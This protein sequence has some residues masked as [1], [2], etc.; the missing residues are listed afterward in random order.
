MT[1]IIFSLHLEQPLL[2][3]SFQGDPNT[4][5][6][7]PYIPGSMIRG[8]L[9][10]RYLKHNR[11]QDS[12]IVV[13]PKIRQLFFEDTT[14]Y[15]NAYPL[16]KDYDQP[17]SLPVPRCLYKRKEDELGDERPI[18][19]YDLTYP[20]SSTLPNDVSLKGLK[21][22]NFCT[23]SDDSLTLYSVSN[24]LNIHNKRD[25]RRGRATIQSGQVFR[26]DA[27]DAGQTF[28]AV[29]LTGSSNTEELINLLSSDQYLWLG[30]SQSAGYGQVHICDISIPSDE[31]CEVGIPLHQRLNRKALRITLLSDCILRDQCGQH[32]VEPPIQLLSEALGVELSLVKSYMSSNFIGGF[33]RKWGLPLPQ[34]QTIAAGSVFVF[35]GVELSSTR[36]ADVEFC[37]IGERRNEGFGRVTVNWLDD[38]GEFTAR[39][40]QISISTNEIR[41]ESIASVGL[42]AL[43]AERIL[44]QKLD[45]LLIDKLSKINIEGKISNSQLSRLMIVAR[46]ALNDDNPGLVIELL[47]N[48]PS[49]A[50]GQFERSKLKDESVSNNREKVKILDTRLREWLSQPHSCWRM[51]NDVTIAGET[52]TLADKLAREYTLRLI[53]AVAKKANKER[54]HEQQLA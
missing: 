1:A 19:L 46:Q 45:E 39:R 33:N 50:R 9:I 27:I 5:V 31:W 49:N 53:M 23:V 12:D 25:R 24:R 54:K 47:D 32:I 10:G 7:Y 48:V 4:D 30:G 37:G 26:Y 13:D 43:M 2:A 22:D 34:I 41:L 17:R 20:S 21:E 44:R 16:A 15:L 52:F 40:F 28:Q 51:L 8:A 3:T 42:A 36:V 38:I 29:I 14:R 18:P 35:K 6:S 11:I